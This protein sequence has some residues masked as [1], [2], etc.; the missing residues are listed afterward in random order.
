MYPFTDS[1]CV[2]LFSLFRF[3]FYFHMHIFTQILRHRIHGS[4]FASIF[5]A[6]FSAKNR[7]LLCK[8]DVKFIEI[9]GG[10]T[11]EV[12]WVY[13]YMNMEYERF[14]KT[15]LRL[16]L[17]NMKPSLMLVHGTV[18][19][20]SQNRTTIYPTFLWILSVKFILI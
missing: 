1:V 15:R 4:I 19:F 13:D 6:K 9:V 14:V 12:C 8:M 7:I 17:L 18:F 2:L 11:H 20:C 16:H 5:S 10:K 3:A